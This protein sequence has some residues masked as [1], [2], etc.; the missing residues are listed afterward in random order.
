MSAEKLSSFQVLLL[1][2]RRFH[3]RIFVFNLCKASR[4]LSIDTSDEYVIMRLDDSETLYANV[5]D[6]EPLTLDD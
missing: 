1:K 3:R 2:K 4:A 6:N 5:S